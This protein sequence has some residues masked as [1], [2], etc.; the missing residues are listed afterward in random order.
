MANKHTNV[1]AD[2]I[3]EEMKNPPP[4]FEDVLVAFTTAR[5]KTCP[6]ATDETMA[7]CLVNDGSALLSIFA[8]AARYRWLRRGHAY[9]P[10]EAGIRGGVDLDR[11]CDDGMQERLGGTVVWS[12]ETT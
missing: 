9:R 2:D 1:S 8:D 6:E 7:E 3:V 4:A 5:L 11:L 10:E 12:E